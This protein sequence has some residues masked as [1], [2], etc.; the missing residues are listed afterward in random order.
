MNR[1]T[2]AVSHWLGLFVERIIRR[3]A[4]ENRY[5]WLMDFLIHNSKSVLTTPKEIVKLPIYL[6]GSINIL[7]SL[8]RHVSN[9]Y[10]LGKGFVS[11]ALTF[12]TL[13]VLVAKQ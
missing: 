2:L 11:R 10:D 3:E 9:S 12:L 5:Q 4:G 7:A 1:Q 6:Y 13:K 8:F